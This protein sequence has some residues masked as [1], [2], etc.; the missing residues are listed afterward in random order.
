MESLFLDVASLYRLDSGV[1]AGEELEGDKQEFGRLPVESK[2]LLCALAGA[3]IC[4]FMY[5]FYEKRKK[6]D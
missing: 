4:I 3:W 5:I 1:A 6:K 2:I